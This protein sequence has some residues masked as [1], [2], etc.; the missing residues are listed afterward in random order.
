MTTTSATDKQTRTNETV[1]A[2]RELF[3]PCAPPLYEE[4]LVLVEGR[5]AQVY[6]SDGNEYL[7]FFSGI[8]TTSLGHC[9]PEVVER[10]REQVGKLGHTSTLYLNE[11][12]VRVSQR[13]G[14]I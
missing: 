3:F 2:Y 8:L 11:C 14:L 1:S 6:D 10:V 9:H 4:P 7:D 13:E 12:Q 5:G